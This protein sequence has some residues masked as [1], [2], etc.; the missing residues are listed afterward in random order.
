MT[1]SSQ[2]SS[3]TSLTTNI[4]LISRLTTSS[5]INLMSRA[6]PF[7]PFININSPNTNSPINPTNNKF[8]PRSRRIIK[9]E[10]NSSKIHMNLTSNR[11]AK[12]GLQ[13]KFNLK[14]SINHDSKWSLLNNSTTMMPSPSMQISIRI[15][16]S[17]NTRLLE[18]NT[19]ALKKLMRNHSS[20]PSKR[21]L[22]NITI[23]KTKISSKISSS[24]N[25]MIAWG[26]CMRIWEARMRI[27]AA[28][29]NLVKAL[30]KRKKSLKPSRCWTH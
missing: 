20:N 21:I 11:T 4:S 16:T 25:Q 23:S 12:E 28:P 9:K 19:K 14:T 30:A 7:N 6:L 13:N 2:G 3:C 8:N 29:L 18:T 15:L 26:P 5:N 1:V 22:T 17:L 10:I 27:W 24:R